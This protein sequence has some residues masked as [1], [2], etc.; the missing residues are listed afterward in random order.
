MSLIFRMLW[1]ILS[2]YFKPHL[3]SIGVKNSLSLRVL[4][5]DLDINMHMNNGR[6][7]TICDLTRVDLF[8]RSGLAGLMMKKGWRPIISEHT[9]NYK[10]GLKP[11]QKYQIHMEVKDWDDRVFNM[12]HTFMVGELVVAEGTSKGVIVG[13]DGVVPPDHVIDAVDQYNKR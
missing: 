10:K 3:P 12:V 1:V 13:R 2:S 9:M 6:Y 5:N 8:M 11:F 7:L 4:P